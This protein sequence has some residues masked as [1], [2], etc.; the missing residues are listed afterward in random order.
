[1]PAKNRVKTYVINGIYHVYNRGVNKMEVYSDQKDEKV[2]LS[3]LKNYLLP[4]DENEL[5]TRMSQPKSSEEKRQIVK[6]LARNNF[7]EK[8]ELLAYC[9]MPNHYHFLIKQ[10]GV[11]DLTS[12]MKSV[13]TR[14]VQYF[15]GKYSRIGPLFQG[16]YKAVLVESEEQLLHLSRYIHRNP[17]I[18]GT[19]LRGRS[20]LGGRPSSYPNYLRE[21]NQAWVKPEMILEYFKKSGKG[22]YK[23]FVEDE[24]VEDE[25]LL[26][27]VIVEML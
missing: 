13:M 4:R 2:F 16:R 18:K 14:Y 26:N 9:L 11:N 25:T 6:Q 21:V 12:F 3:Y 7:S 24:D 23:E 10:A 17:M 22:S 20:S 27:G 1:M 15:N 19:V 5:L 8:I